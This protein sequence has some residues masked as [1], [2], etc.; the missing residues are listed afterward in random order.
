[1]FLENILLLL[2]SSLLFDRNIHFELGLLIRLFTVGRG[3]LSLRVD[4]IGRWK[5]V[6]EGILVRNGLIEGVG[7][8]HILIVIVGAEGIE[9]D[10]SLIGRSVIRICCAVVRE[11]H[12]HPI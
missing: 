11:I 6:V 10:R 9:V 2:L 7:G 8:L 5:R 3:T 12:H 4:F 1:V